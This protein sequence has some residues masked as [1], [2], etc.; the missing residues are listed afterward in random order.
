MTTQ[1][2][3]NNLYVLD[4]KLEIV[5]SITG[6]AEG[7]EIKSARFMGD[8]GYFVTYR[9]TDPLFTVDLSEPSKPKLMD[10]LKI[11]GYSSYLHFMDEDN[12]LGIGYESN[13]DTGIKTGIK[14]TL[15]DVADKSDV[16]VKNNLQY[17][18][19]TLYSEVILN[20]KAVMTSESKGIYGF[21]MYSYDYAPVI[22]EEW[23]EADVNC[24]VT[25]Q[26]KVF[27]YK[28]GDI[29]EVES[30]EKTEEDDYAVRGLYIGDYFYLISGD[31]AYVYNLDEVVSDNT[32][33]ELLSIS[34]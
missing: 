31:K 26:Y 32:A 28:D 11:T 15:F 23:N 33:T 10:E 13:P 4:E 9:N 7:E 24:E 14:V 30:I 19:E 12:L 2:S 5:G 8:T 20:H 6:L 21:C 29:R 18:G 17:E 27:L 25:Y 3:G 16:K 1:Y 22:D 34:Y